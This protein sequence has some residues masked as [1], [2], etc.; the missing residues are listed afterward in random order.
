MRCNIRGKLRIN[1]HPSGRT[2]RGSKIHAVRYEVV[3]SKNFFSRQNFDSKAR[4][5]SRAADADGGHEANIRPGSVARWSFWSLH[6]RARRR[7]ASGAATTRARG[8]GGGDDSSSGGGGGGG[9]GK[10]GGSAVV[11][12]A[13]T[14]LQ[15]SVDVTQINVYQA[16]EVVIVQSSKAA[17]HR[18]RSSPAGLRCSA[19]SCLRQRV[20]R[21][22]HRAASFRRRQRQSARSALAIAIGER[23]VL[24]ER[25][26]STINFDVPAADLVSGGKF[27]VALVDTGASRRRREPRA[28]RAIRKT[29]RSIATT[30]KTRGR[31]RSSSSPH[32]RGGYPPDTRASQVQTLHDTMFAM[33]PVTDVQITVHAQVSRLTASRRRARLDSRTCWS[34]EPTCARAKSAR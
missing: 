26:R 2:S 33:Y 8:G 32:R 11:P 31:S 18:R 6:A 16:T 3:G 9:G 24:R 4:L 15:Q 13:S 7:A 22:R 5:R 21:Q 30:R 17:S 20:Q 23:G 28:P 19:C 29:A 10:D 1:R 34:G 12:P 14:Q 25:S 27:S